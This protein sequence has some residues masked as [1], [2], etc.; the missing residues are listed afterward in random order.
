MDVAACTVTAMTAILYPVAET[1]EAALHSPRG[2]AARDR[3]AQMLAD[4][5][6]GFVTEVVG[7]AFATRAAALDAYGGR[8]EDERPGANAVAAE[9][10]WG[11]LVPVSSV[12]GAPAAAVG[13]LQ[14]V[15]SQGRR[16]PEP[17][18]AAP[19]FWRLSISYWRIGGR[20]EAM[21]FPEAPEAER[22]AAR[23]IRRGQAGRSLAA[24]A[25]NALARQPLRAVRP[26]Q[27][28]DIGLFERRPPEAPDTLIPD[29]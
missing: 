17:G 24:P 12:S 14:P 8:V 15:Y 2:Y 16:W 10:R 27:P 19:V 6:V 25:L 18:R 3:E 23:R 13:Q 20:Q 7:P 28:L 4:A 29:E 21:A 1:A 11:Q 22:D 9:A 5:E 26:Q